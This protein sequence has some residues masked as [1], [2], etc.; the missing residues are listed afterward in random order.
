MK[1]PRESETHCF[2]DERI[3]SMARGRCLLRP[4]REGGRDSYFGSVVRGGAL[5][6]VADDSE[7]EGLVFERK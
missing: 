1:G 2:K 3:C 6:Y 4:H 7:M 5:V